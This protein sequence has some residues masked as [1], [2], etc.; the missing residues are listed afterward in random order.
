MAMLVAFYSWALRCKFGRWFY[1]YA[2]MIGIVC[3]TINEVRGYKASLASWSE[4]TDSMF[5]D[6]KDERRQAFASYS[7]W[8]RQQEERTHWV[9]RNIR[10]WFSG[11]PGDFVRQSGG[12]ARLDLPR[13]T[14]TQ[15]DVEMPVV[16]GGED[17]DEETQSE[18]A[19]RYR[20][21][22]LEECSDPGLW[23]SLHH[24]EGL[25]ELDSEAAS[26]MQVDSEAP[27]DHVAQT[28]AVEDYAATA[29]RAR[30][31]FWRRQNEFL[32]AGDYD[33][34]DRFNSRYS[35]LDFVWCGIHEVWLHRWLHPCRGRHAVVLH[36][37]V[38]HPIWFW[39]CWHDLCIWAQAFLATMSC[40]GYA[41]SHWDSPWV[42]HL[43]T[44]HSRLHFW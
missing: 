22:K 13:T 16:D 5:E 21:L 41:T 27:T 18:K 11:S 10:S 2:L 29:E 17:D 6:D 43:C 7:R 4:L 31:L 36:R 9:A 35:W 33:G 15:T 40:I 25:D 34:L 20:H 42:L 24:H 26:P 37:C 38:W 23:M 14:G 1:C 19:L 32:E 3:W 44:L 39:F 8:K 28:S 12:D 30:R